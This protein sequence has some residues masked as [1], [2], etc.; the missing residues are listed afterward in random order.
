M[1][2]LNKTLSEFDSEQGDLFR[3]VFF[4]VRGGKGESVS[5]LNSTTGFVGV[6]NLNC[7]KKS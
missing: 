6:L 7:D 4:S 3:A 5:K 2:N 1:D